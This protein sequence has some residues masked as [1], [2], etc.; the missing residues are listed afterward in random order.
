MSTSSQLFARG[1]YKTVEEKIVHFLNE[2]KHIF[3]KY[4][5]NNPRSV[6]GAL[7]QLLVEN[8]GD[9]IGLSRYEYVE[10]S[11]TRKSLGDLEFS[12]KQQT[13]M[14]YIVDIK[15]HR[16]DTKFNMPNL[17]SSKRLAE[18]YEDEHNIFVIAM[19]DYK[20]EKPDVKV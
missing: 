12:D 11:A 4:S 18:L 15:T 6:G 19:I 17:T 20:I 3:N 1:D 10:Q 13:E 16:L 7:E 2:Q 9:I 14:R 5:L 8:F